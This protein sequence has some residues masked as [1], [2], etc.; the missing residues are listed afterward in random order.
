MKVPDPDN[1]GQEIEVFTPAEIEAR[2]KVKDDELAQARE[3]AEKYKILSD[4]KTQ[5]F[6]RLNE[7]TVEEKAAL[8]ADKIAAIQRAEAA[9]DRV[10]ALEEAHSTD[11]QNRIKTDTEKALEKYHGGNEK[12]KE[13]LEANFKMINIEGTDTASI[14]ERAR[15]AAS[16]EMGKNND[17]HEP[18]MSAMRGGEAPKP[19]DKEGKSF[20]EGDKG[21]KA[22]DQMGWDPE[23]GE[24]K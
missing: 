12:L 14:E 6:K 3:D 21:K 4:E 11:T 1:E 15:L 16:M 2:D 23:A 9:E 8:S 20:A 17:N 10:K 7:M 19:R 22:F 5:N 24:Q 18:L 13:A